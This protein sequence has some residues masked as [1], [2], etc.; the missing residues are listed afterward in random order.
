MTDLPIDNDREARALALNLAVA[1]HK[2]LVRIADTKSDQAPGRVVL[3]DAK[4]FEA[5]IRTGRIPASHRIKPAEG[6]VQ[7]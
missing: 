3:A 2:D 5:F 1:L 6:E 4:A 7:A